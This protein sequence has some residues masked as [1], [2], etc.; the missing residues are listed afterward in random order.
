V[1]SSLD[2]SHYDLELNELASH[3]GMLRTDTESVTSSSMGGEIQIVDLSTG[4][5]QTIVVKDDRSESDINSF[6]PIHQKL[7]LLPVISDEEDNSDDCLDESGRSN[8]LV[9]HR[10][11]SAPLVSSF[12]YSK[13]KLFL[14]ESEIVQVEQVAGK[15][16]PD[17]LPSDKQLAI[18]LEKFAQVDNELKQHNIRK[19]ESVDSR[20]HDVLDTAVEGSL[21]DNLIR[22]QESDDFDDENDHVEMMMA[23][24]NT[25]NKSN[26]IISQKENIMASLYS[27]S[28]HEKTTIRM[29]NTESH[30]GVIVSDDEN[31]TSSLGLDSPPRNFLY[32]DEVEV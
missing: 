10:E 7:Q 12:S 26:N 25:G 28:M 24:R 6:P 18:L 20:W 13:P 11:E 4:G 8:S 21:N 29:D 23:L 9:L 27:N 5:R 14:K 19:D 22:Y 30:V 1:N 2:D 31:E 32:P 17:K 15:P 3:D 16:K